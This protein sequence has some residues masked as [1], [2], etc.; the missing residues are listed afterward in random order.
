M[1]VNQNLIN[2][3]PILPNPV[4]TES[5]RVNFINADS[6]QQKYKPFL[7][8][9]WRICTVF[10]CFFTI[11]FYKTTIGFN[12]VIFTLLAILCTHLI[13]SRIYGCKYSIFSLYHILALVFAVLC[14]FTTNRYFLF[15]QIILI[16]SFL[17][18]ESFKKI[19]PDFSLFEVIL[20]LKFIKFCFT[21]VSTLFY[22]IIHLFHRSSTERSSNRKK[23]IIL[24]IVAAF[25]FL[26]FMVPILLS[27][28]IVFEHLFL[29]VSNIVF[30]SS[31]L[32]VVFLFF[33]GFFYLYCS[34]MGNIKTKE[35]K[36][37]HS[38]E[39]KVSSTSSFELSFTFLKTFYLFVNIVYVIFSGSLLYFIFSFYFKGI[40]EKINY[41]SYVHSGFYQLIFASVINLILIS[42]S[43]RYVKN[44]LTLKLLL[45]VTTLC[46]YIMLLSN[47]FRMSLYVKAY[48]L[49]FLRVFVLFL[50]LIIA[51][52]ML[53]NISHIFLPRNFFFRNHLFL[54]IGLYVLFVI[55]TPDA[56]IAKYNISHSTTQSSADTNYLVYGLSLDAATVVYPYLEKKAIDS[57]SLSQRDSLTNY[58]DRMSRY[59]KQSHVRNFQFNYF[60]IQHLLN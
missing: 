1:D 29:H 57:S 59:L 5:Q 52:F 27:S 48:S 10:A 47:L 36:E 16:L 14:T 3:Q 34:I 23:D 40:Q 19:E 41:A 56:F 31:M 38:D 33:V 2:Q 17:V 44:D 24:G 30:G 37:K 15:L 58:K 18:L 51:I 21:L 39:I 43:T 32:L 9:I 54:V 35:L 28:D 13:F 11:F 25:I 22:P 4:L 12:I 7:S 50:S 26:L 6:I 49:S 53:A 60:S 8:F 46:T 20:N 42:F 55:S 45:L